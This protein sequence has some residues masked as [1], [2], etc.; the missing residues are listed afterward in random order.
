MEVTKNSNIM[1]CR[2]RR[3]LCQAPKSRR[4]AIPKM[5]KSLKNG[6]TNVV[7][8][9]ES[10]N[11]VGKAILYLHYFRYGL[12]RQDEYKQKMLK[13]QYMVLSALLLHIT[14]ICLKVHITIHVQQML[15]PLL[16][17]IYA[18]HSYIQA[19]SKK[20][21][22]EEKGALEAPQAANQKAQIIVKNDVN[23]PSF[24]SLPTT[25]KR[26][27]SDVDVAVQAAQSA[28]EINY[29]KCWKND[30][31]NLPYLN[32]RKSLNYDNRFMIRMDLQPMFPTYV[33][34]C[35]P[36]WKP[37]E[38]HQGRFL[39]RGSFGVVCACQD[40]YGGVI[41]VKRVSKL[42]FKSVKEYERRAP[43]LE[44]EMWMQADVV[45]PNVI[46]PYGYWRDDT[47][48]YCAFEIAEN[49]TVEEKIF[50]SSN[51]DGMNGKAMAESSAAVVIKDVALGLA[52]CHRNGV[53]HCDVKGENVLIS[54]D[55]VHKI[56][57]FGLAVRLNN[58]DHMASKRTF[59]P[60]YAA[61][62]FRGD[63][64]YGTKVDSWS[65]GF[66][67]YELII[68]TRMWHNIISLGN[69]Y[70]P[71]GGIEITDGVRDLLT[72]LLCKNPEER[73]SCEDVLEHQWLLQHCK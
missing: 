10:L 13:Q 8:I 19:S 59:E 64:K 3:R 58:Y 34:P 21:I 38:V 67:L 4:V 51:D 57:D 72:K 20:S 26:T 44:D 17:S 30:I 68:G 27:E 63:G 2:S 61:P 60:L 28:K 39:G 37:T 53:V 43:L 52:G 66:L 48:F 23:I 71:T 41:A 24:S 18:F 47:S 65:L 5:N 49:G 12:K 54:N 32:P 16:H 11:G 69:N 15:R 56:C 14:M 29:E 35:L 6:E 25:S 9:D 55:G 31:I 36:G 46:C 40:S 33:T 22:N 42:S 45:G 70:I 62:E 7:K 1:I 73:I 50:G